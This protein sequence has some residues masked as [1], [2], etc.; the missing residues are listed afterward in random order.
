VKPA[1][2]EAIEQLKGQYPDST[3]DVR[4]DGQGGAH[5]LIDPVD[6]GQIYTEGT[7]GT[8]ISFHIPFQVPFADVYP[9]HVRRDLARADGRPLGEA[10]SHAEAPVFGRLSVQLS[11]RSNHRDPN[12][13][14]VLHK[15]LKVIEWAST[16]P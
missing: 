7:R 8:W 10:M 14:T 11:R 12:H 9:H 5:V 2:L 6:L 16:R 13:E 4:E 1:V 3:F 15:L